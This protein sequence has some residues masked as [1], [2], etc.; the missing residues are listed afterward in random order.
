MNM[1]ALIWDEVK[2]LA[3]VLHMP[4]DDAVQFFGGYYLE[5]V[6][7]GY[8]I[9]ADT[10]NIVRNYDSHPRS[11]EGRYLF[12]QPSD[13]VYAVIEPSMQVTGR[14]DG[15]NEKGLVM[16]YNFTHRKQSA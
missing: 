12:Y 13:S 3:D 15:M 7:S 9:F 2:G 6:R 11:Y 14:I 8:S 4:R 1:E 5:F 16:G 10:Y